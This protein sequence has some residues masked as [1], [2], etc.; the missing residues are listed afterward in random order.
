TT[1]WPFKACLISKDLLECSDSWKLAL[2][3]LTEGNRSNECS[4]SLV[5]D[6]IVLAGLAKS[7]DSNV[8]L[9]A[10]FYRVSQYS[11]NLSLITLTLI[12]KALTLLFFLRLGGAIGMSDLED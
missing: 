9:D 8:V 2:Q 5:N 7:L 11:E 12:A 4:N 1:N 6:S 3:D 10:D